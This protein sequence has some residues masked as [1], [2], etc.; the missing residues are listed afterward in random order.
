MKFKDVEL[1]PGVVINVDDP[2]MQG[3]IKAAIP[4]VFDTE[5]M[6]E[7]GLP[8]IYPLTMHGFQGFSKMMKGSKIW[9]FKQDNNYREF[10]YIPMFALNENTKQV[11]SSYNEP[12]VLI[13]R[14]A[15]EESIYI[16]YNDTDG[17]KCQIGDAVINIAHDKTI[18]IYS[19]SSAITVNGNGKITIGN[20]DTEFEPTVLGN[21]L[22]DVLAQLSTDLKQIG[23]SA[24]G[25]ILDPLSPLFTVASQ[26]LTNGINNI[27]ATNT[28][29]N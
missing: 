3:R 4:G 10:W 12:D 23:S 21:K 27:K 17:I 1:L 16:Y 6:N 7:E 9:V 2:K 22:Y 24:H 14:S 20:K 26:N 28:L 8:W 5:T 19:G 11:V 13:S 15:G 29:V 18:Y 25:N